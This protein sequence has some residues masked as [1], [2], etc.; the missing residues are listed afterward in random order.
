MSYFVATFFLLQYSSCNKALFIIRDVQTT[1]IDYI[2]AIAGH[3]LKTYVHDI[4]A[5]IHLN[6][7]DGDWVTMMA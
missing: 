5:S 7:K 3:V 4:K 2:A 1:C 6:N